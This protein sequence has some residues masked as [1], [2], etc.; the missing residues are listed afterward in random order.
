MTGFE[1]DSFVVEVAPVV[2]VAWVV[3]TVVGISKQ[4]MN[5]AMFHNGAHFNLYHQALHIHSSK[6]I[7]LSHTF[8]CKASR[9]LDTHC[10]V[11]TVSH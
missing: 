11:C 2:S 6:I 7:P 10:A 3:G 9:A 8:K 4:D 5:I 1:W